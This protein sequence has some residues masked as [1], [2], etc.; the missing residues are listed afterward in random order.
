M[1]CSMRHL[2]IPFF[3][4]W[5]S[6][7]IGSDRGAS[8]CF[9]HFFGFLHLRDPISRRVFDDIEGYGAASAKRNQA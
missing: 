6:R 7:F 8:T 3:R 9:V 1:L 5:S 2:L 4:S